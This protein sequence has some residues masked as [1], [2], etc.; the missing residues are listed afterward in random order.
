[1]PSDQ[2]VE[3]LLPCPFCGC[4]DISLDND[5]DYEWLKCDR[6]GAVGGVDP[7]PEHE[8]HSI[9]WH[10]NRRPHTGETAASRCKVT[11]NPVG[12]DTWRVGYECRC[13]PCREYQAASSIPQKEREAVAWRWKNWHSACWYH[14][15]KVPL[16]AVEFEPLFAAL[17]QPSK[18]EGQ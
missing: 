11:G 16:G 9:Q 8:G 10:W 7:A 5:G 3:A 1:M 18:G 6:C 14:G 12:T 17:S 2:E 15:T 4:T 13:A